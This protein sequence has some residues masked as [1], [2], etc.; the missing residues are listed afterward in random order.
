MGVKKELHTALIVGM[1]SIG[2]R[3]CR[4]LQKLLPDIRIIALRHLRCLSGYIY[5]DIG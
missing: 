4:L 1:G 3:H 5:L 2:R